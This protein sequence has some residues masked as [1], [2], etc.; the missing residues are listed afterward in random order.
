MTAPPLGIVEGY[1]GEPWSW[2]ERAAQVAFLAP[3]G[4]EFFLYAPKFDEYLRRQWQEDH[5]QD[6]ADSLA[7][8]A[9]HCRAHGVRF[10]VGLSPY[11]LYRDFGAST[12]EALGRKLAFFDAIGVE[13][14]GVFFD[15]MR[16]DLPDVA[17]QQARILNWIAERSGASRLVC[18][19]T[20]YN[21]D[22]LL[23]RLFGQR[24]PG[25]LADLGRALDPAIDLFWTGP[26]TCSLEYTPGHLARVAEEMGRLPVLWDNYPVNDG[27]RM[28]PYLHLRAMTGRGARIGPHLAGHAVNPALQPVLSRIP[29]LSL[30]DSYRLGDDYDYGRAFDA[31]AKA[32]LGEVIA[33]H[34]RGHLGL[35]QDTGLSRIDADLKGKLRARYA[36][37][38]H[39]G[40]K[41]I[42][43]FLDGRWAAAPVI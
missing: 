8:L 23:D 12:K 37:F 40:A 10:G 29:C 33:G 28:S 18:C 13:Y 17:G 30:V 11:E 25:Y 5:P 21:D 43:D 41:E 32:V 36:A 20:Y 24:P 35:F 3:H 1:Y 26:D 42:V 34:V 19:P 39:P 2:A 9:A 7:K 14:L 31:A 6:M 15:D 22:P 27:A 4:F 16:G 38:D